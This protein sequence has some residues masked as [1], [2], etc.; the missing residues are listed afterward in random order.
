MGQMGRQSNYEGSG[1]E[2]AEGE[3]KIKKRIWNIRRKDGKV[4]QEK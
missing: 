2:K 4:D 3:D 1:H